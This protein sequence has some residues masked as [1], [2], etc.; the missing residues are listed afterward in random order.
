MLERIRTLSR[1][2]RGTQ[3][4]DPVESTPIFT[5]LRVFSAQMLLSTGVNAT[6]HYLRA[7]SSRPASAHP[8]NGQ[9]ARWR[10]AASAPDRSRDPGGGAWAPAVLGSLGCAAQATLALRAS[11]RALLA[12]RVL[13]GLVLGV[14]V[15]GA[16]QSLRVSIKGEAPFTFA[17]LL[18]GYAGLFGFLVD[19]Q[20]H[21]V[22]EDEAALVRRSRILDRLIPERRTRIDRIVVHV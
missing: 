13:N 8:G 2:A 22:A 11:D 16:A 19:R 14:G 20:E 3:E 21:A 10:T 1:G 9:E 6:L 7:R 5:A 12:T 4:E 15:A 17:P 18:F